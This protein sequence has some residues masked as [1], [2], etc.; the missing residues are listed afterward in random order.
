VI[1]E[2]AHCVCLV[3]THDFLRGHKESL[4]LEG[5]YLNKERSYPRWRKSTFEENIKSN[6]ELE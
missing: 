4:C 3:V 5:V 6:V 1:Y 2:A